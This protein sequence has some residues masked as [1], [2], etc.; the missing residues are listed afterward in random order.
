MAPSPLN[1][2]AETVRTLMI[3]IKKTSS[4]TTF[5]IHMAAMNVVDRAVRDDVRDPSGKLEKID[6]TKGV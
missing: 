5:D 3:W 6:E 4:S 1:G 2:L